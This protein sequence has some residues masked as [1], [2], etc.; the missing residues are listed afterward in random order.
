MKRR[1]FLSII[2]GAFGS[3]LISPE[4]AIRIHEIAMGNADP[5]ILAPL[6]PSTS[7]L[8]VESC[9]RY[10]LHLGDPY[11]EPDY[12]SLREFIEGK[13]FYPDDDESARAYLE[14]TYLAGDE[15]EREIRAHLKSLRLELDNPIDGSERDQWLEWEYILQECTMAAAFRYLELLP[16]KDGGSSEG[17]RLGQVSFIEGPHPGSNSTYVEVDGL[18]GIASLQHRLNQLGEG[19]RIEVE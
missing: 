9:G 10:I 6:N 2:S 5:R 19:V 13:G 3:C 11:A 7:L 8:A 14:E 4:T 1:S 15:S 18:E 17:E 16:L 12:P